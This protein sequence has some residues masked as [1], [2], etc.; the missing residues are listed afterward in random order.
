M[1]NGQKLQ[2]PETAAEV[3]YMLKARVRKEPAHLALTSLL[4][5]AI[6]YHLPQKEVYFSVHQNHGNRAWRVTSPCS[7]QCTASALGNSSL[8][9]CSPPSG[10][11]QSTNNNL[12]HQLTNSWYVMVISSW[13]RCHSFEMLPVLHLSL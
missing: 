12:G 2:G 13:E 7:R 1:L 5:F 6:D 8:R 4:S 9:T 3:N 10:T 11:T